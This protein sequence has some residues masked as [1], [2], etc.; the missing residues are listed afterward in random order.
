M[1]RLWFILINP[2][3]AQVPVGSLNDC[4]RAAQQIEQRNG[5]AVD[6]LCRKEGG[7]DSM[8]ANNWPGTGHP[9]YIRYEHRTDANRFMPNYPKPRPK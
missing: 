3:M 7:I 1:W 4:L 5:G 8:Y 6:V 9:A 2:D